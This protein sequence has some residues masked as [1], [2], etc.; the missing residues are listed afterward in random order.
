[1]LGNR[2]ALAALFAAPFFVVSNA[3]GFDVGDLDNVIEGKLKHAFGEAPE[4]EA[5][6]SD[7]IMTGVKSGIANARQRIDAFSNDLKH[8]GSRPP[9][10]ML[11]N[12]IAGMDGQIDNVIGIVG[13]VLAPAS[14]GLHESTVHDIL[15]PTFQS[16]T[17]GVDVLLHDISGAPVDLLLAPAM[18]ML[19]GNLQNLEH[20]AAIY[21]L[22]DAQK[23]L[24]KQRELIASHAE[25]GTGFLK[26]GGQQQHDQH[27][28][29][30]Q[31]HDQHANQQHHDHQQQQHHAFW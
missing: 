9:T 1:M 26:K 27:G 21:K 25:K 10:S 13:K 7:P 29:H 23:K 19:S 14:G 8:A 3:A 5:R 12:F 6:G 30:D 28:H 16:V 11:T 15:A 22:P 20:I 2:L 24:A 17:N 4:L 31:H 18:H